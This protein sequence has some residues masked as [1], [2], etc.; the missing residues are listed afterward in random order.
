MLILFFRNRKFKLGDLL[1][2]L[3]MSQIF[4]PFI[5]D[6]TETSLLMHFNFQMCFFNLDVANILLSPQE[7]C[8]CGYLVVTWCKSSL[9]ITGF[10]LPFVIY[11][12]YICEHFKVY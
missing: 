1:L 3:F 7:V 6:M 12:L 8:H 5:P 11:G 4:Q 10:P 2:L 9:S